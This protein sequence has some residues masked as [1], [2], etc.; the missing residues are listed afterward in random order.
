MSTVTTR[1][2]DD[3]PTDPTEF[4][5]CLWSGV[6]GQWSH[7]ANF[8]S[9]ELAK[10]EAGTATLKAAVSTTTPARRMRPAS[11]SALRPSSCGGHSATERMFHD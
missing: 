10:L 7:V 1:D 6:A 5:E 8:A 4:A 3:V 2:P 11:P 9:A